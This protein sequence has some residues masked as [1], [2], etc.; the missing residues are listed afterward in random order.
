[1]RNIFANSPKITNKYNYC[2]IFHIA[3][4]LLIVEANTSA[5]RSC[6]HRIIFVQNFEKINKTWYLRT[7]HFQEN[8]HLIGYTPSLGIDKVRNTIKYC[9]ATLQH[10]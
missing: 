1:M 10:K 6:L 3:C 9:R 7:S 5:L 2:F 4:N 8:L